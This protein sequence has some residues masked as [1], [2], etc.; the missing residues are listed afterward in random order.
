MRFIDF[1]SVEY[2]Y[3][4]SCLL[5]RWHVIGAIYLYCFICTVVIYLSQMVAALVISFQVPIP[6]PSIRHDSSQLYL[7]HVSHQQC[8]SNH[9]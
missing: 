5:S 8:F 9:F 6:N 3:L 7:T 4:L 1:D 2:T